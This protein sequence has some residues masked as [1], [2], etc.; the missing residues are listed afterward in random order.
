[1]YDQNSDTFKAHID[2]FGRVAKEP[3][4]L[5]ALVC[6]NVFSVLQCVG[7]GVLQCSAVC[8]SVW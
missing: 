3:F 4:L 7:S 8:G 1:M 5:E 6:Y 2:H